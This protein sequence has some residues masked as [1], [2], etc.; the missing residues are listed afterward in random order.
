MP[1]KGAMDRT[2][3]APASEPLSSERT[4]AV[5][6]RAVTRRFGDVVA[7]SDLT[8]S[9]RTGEVVA[10]VGPSGCGK[11]TLLELVAG[12]QEP[13]G[14]SVGAVPAALMP[15]RDLLLPWRT[16]LANAA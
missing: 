5:E 9:V 13:D 12:L 14:G 7:L 2:V 15:Q 6:L 10:L 8:L 1:A 4:T 16:A 11:S 3:E